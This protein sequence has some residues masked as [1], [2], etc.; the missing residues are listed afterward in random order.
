[1]FEIIVDDQDHSLGLLRDGKAIGTI[2]AEFSAIQ[3]GNVHALGTMRYIAVASS[4]FVADHFSEGI[5]A[6]TLAK[7]PMLAFNRKDELQSSLIHTTTGHHLIPPT[8]YLPTLIGFVEAP[9]QRM[10]WCMAPDS[11]V[12]SALK[13]RTVERLAPEVCLDTP[14]FWQHA[15][16]ASST[17][18][19]ITNI[20]MKISTTM[21]HTS[22]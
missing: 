9:A 16:V 21:R 6:S 3:G 17:L 10:G 15:A 13:S 12:C 18:P 11:L 1:M 7:A 2:T 4:R 14:L 22:P 19:R 20:L 5:N 8:H